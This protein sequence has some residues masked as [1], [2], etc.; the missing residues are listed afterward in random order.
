MRTFILFSVLLG[1]FL[2][3]GSLWGTFGMLTALIFSL[4]LNFASY[5]YSDK[6]VLAIY[7]AKI[8]SKKESPRLYRV[9]EK[10]EC[11]YTVISYELVQKV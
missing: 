1:I 9:V 6:V 11:I 3:V 5:W 4:I 2:A 7:R 10:L 8:V